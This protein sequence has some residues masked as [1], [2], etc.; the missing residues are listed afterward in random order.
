MA[1]AVGTNSYIDADEAS[2]YF[3]DWTCPAFLESV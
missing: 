2:A 1:L 3:A